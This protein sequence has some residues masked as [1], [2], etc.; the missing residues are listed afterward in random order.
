MNLL[1]QHSVGATSRAAHGADTTSP[2][3]P[4]WRW[5]WPWL[6][7]SSA[8][9]PG[10]GRAPFLCSSC[11]SG[12]VEPVLSG[13]NSQQVPLSPG[14]IGCEPG[15][16]TAAAAPLARSGRDLY[17]PSWTM[18]QAHDTDIRG[19]FYSESYG[20]QLPGDVA[21]PSRTGTRLSGAQANDA[22]SARFPGC[23]LRAGSPSFS[24][25]KF[26]NVNQQCHSRL[27]V[28]HHL[29][30]VEQVANCVFSSVPFSGRL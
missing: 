10:L 9:S 17:R 24:S 15:T 5:P 26:V 21:G 20:W 22:D 14:T 1:P 28:L 6:P 12:C 3:R 4:A 30:E 19:G 7:G 18:V 13:T 2:H 16:H 25:S 11:L 27:L 29:H 23:E 8:A